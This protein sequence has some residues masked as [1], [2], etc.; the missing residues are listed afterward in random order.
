MITWLILITAS[1]TSRWLITNLE[2]RYPVFQWKNHST[3]KT[4]KPHIV[5]LGAGYTY[6]TS[7][8]A[9][10]QISGTVRGRLVE[11]YRIYR[12]SPKAQLITSG[13]N[14]NNHISQGEVVANAAVQLGV[15][16]ADTAF[17]YRGY[18]TRT[19]AKW[20]SKRFPQKDT[21][22]VSTSALHMRRSMFWFRHYGKTPVPAPTNFL[23]KRDPYDPD[24]YFGFS[25]DNID[26]LNKA[27]HEYVGFWYAQWRAGE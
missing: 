7:L 24:P 10:H 19:E 25:F 14:T 6:D 4:Q 2:S 3:L 17:L 23:V 27:I 12:K 11:G 8:L 18:N 26:R 5:A 22:I 9:T 16:P 1:P 21:V 20:F 15:N 13:P